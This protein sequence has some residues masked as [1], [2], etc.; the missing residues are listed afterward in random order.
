M[1]LK[2]KKQYKKALR[3]SENGE[4]IECFHSWDS[5]TKYFNKL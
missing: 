4:N 3:V 5:I 2:P 1:I